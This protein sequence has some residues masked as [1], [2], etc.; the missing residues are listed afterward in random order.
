MISEIKFKQNYP[1]KIVDGVKKI[2]YDAWIKRIMKN[3]P[4]D[5]PK[6]QHRNLC[7]IIK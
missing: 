6:K 5:K 7:E 2:D 1:I 3:W 4:G